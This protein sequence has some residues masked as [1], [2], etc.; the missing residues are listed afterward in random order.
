MGYDYRYPHMHR[1]NDA[2]GVPS[3]Y[4]K[5]M[6]SVADRICR[7]TGLR[8]SYNAFDRTMFFHYTPEPDSGPMRLPVFR[9]EDGSTRRYSDL[10]VDEAVRYVNYGKMSRAMKDKIGQQRR[11]FEQW[12][13]QEKRD[14]FLAERRPDAE[15]LARHLDQKRRGVGKVISAPN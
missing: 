1:L 9:P 11:Q 5:H 8:C 7:R 4:R 15:D 13:A 2:P 6:K 3:D 10:E 12:E 14:K